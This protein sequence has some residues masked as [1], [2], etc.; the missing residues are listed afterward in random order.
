VSI[1]L[2][3]EPLRRAMGDDAWLDRIISATRKMIAPLQTVWL[4][5]DVS[6]QIADVWRR[7]RR[8]GKYGGL[9]MVMVSDDARRSAEGLTAR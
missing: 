3:N 1:E 4:G 8:I 5:F 2:P 7:G 9:P 6:T